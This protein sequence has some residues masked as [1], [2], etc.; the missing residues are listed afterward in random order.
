M[1]STNGSTD[2][3]FAGDIALGG[4]GEVVM[5]NQRQQPHS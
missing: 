4:S 2:L 3:T 1:N 5:S